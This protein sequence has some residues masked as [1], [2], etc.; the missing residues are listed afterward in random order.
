MLANKIDLAGILALKEIVQLLQTIVEFRLLGDQ[1]LNER[2][3]VSYMTDGDVG[4]LKDVL[5]RPRLVPV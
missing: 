2:R 3:K 1:T 5:G 4:G